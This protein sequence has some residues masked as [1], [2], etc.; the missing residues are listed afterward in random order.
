[1]TARGGY[2]AAVRERRPV[3][4]SGLQV[5]PL[6]LGANVFGWSADEPASFAVLDAYLEAGGNVIDTANVY[7]A[8]APGNAGGESESIIGRWMASRGVR[9]QIV[10]ATKVGQA[11]GPGQVRGLGR[12]QIRAGAAASLAR[13]GTDRID[14]YY[15][16][17]D[18]PGVPLG[19]TLGAFDELV[20]EGSVRAIGASNYEPARLAE[21]LDISAER[22]LARYEALQPWFNLVDRDGYQGGL[23][24]LCRAEGLGVM[25]YFALA[26]GFLTGKYRAGHPVPQSARARSVLRDY[27]GPRAA[28]ALAAV[29]AVAGEMGASPAQVALAWLMARPGV[30]AP[31]ASA[32]T[33]EQ[34]RELTGAA[35]LRLSPAQLA[36]LDDAGAPG[37]PAAAR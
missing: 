26:R 31:I 8:W 20:R 27:S 30:T 15:A 10:L 3:G 28:T 36:R 1:M 4:R 34:V 23:E 7:S 14:L 18:D 2:A 11:G 21:A 35:E 29:D 6:C 5:S 16:H 12:A 17:E 32:T 22:G 13:L 33:P 37:P 25:P 24:A 9:D 19:E